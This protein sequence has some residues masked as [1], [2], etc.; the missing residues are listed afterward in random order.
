MNASDWQAEASTPQGLEA[1][2]HCGKPLSAWEQVLLKVDR[3]L[4]CKGCWR[5]ISF[6]GHDDSPATSAPSKLG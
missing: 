4:I 1:C 2:P 3:A 6:P 5:R